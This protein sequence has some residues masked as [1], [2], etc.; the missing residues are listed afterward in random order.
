VKGEPAPPEWERY[1]A[2]AQRGLDAAD[3]VVAPTQAMLAALHGLY[4][5]RV[6]THAIPNGVA[7]AVRHAQKE[8]FVLAA[9]RLWDEAKNLAALDRVAGRVSAPVVVAGDGSSAGR[10]EGARLREL[11]GAAAIYAGPARYEPFGLAALEAG[12]SGC[13]LVLGDIATLREVWDD[14][15]VYVDPFDDDGLAAALERLL[16]D[17]RERQRL[18][19][20]ARRRALSYSRERMAARY[21]DVYRRTLA[22]DR[23]EVA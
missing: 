13:A 22:L 2:A 10:V 21:A 9:G 12:L 18:A 14:A 4:D 11:Y 7:D 8:P 16:A 1:R 6:E 3:A 15:A 5:V 23:V 17:E 20:A 19:R